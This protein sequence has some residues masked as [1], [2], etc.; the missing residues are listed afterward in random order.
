M[1]KALIVTPY[2]A[3]VGGGE[4]YMLSAASAISSLGMQVYF[5]WESAQDIEKIAL[6]LGIELP[7]FRLDKSVSSLYFAKNPL[8]MWQATRN[9]DLVLYLSDGSIPLLGGKK[10]LIHFQVPFHGVNGRSPKNFLKKKLI[11]NFIVNSG[12]T[13]KIIDAEYGISSRI[14]YPPVTEIGMPLHKENL[15]LSAGRFEPTPNIKKQD[16]L[17]E[18]FRQFSN[19]NSSCQLV[20][21]G[22]AG[23]S[24]SLW[25]DKLMEQ[26]K[27]LKISFAVNAPHEKLLDLYRRAT[28]YW[29][30]AGFGVNENTAPELVEHFGITTAESI[31][32]GCIPLVVPSGGQREI[33]ED[34]HFHWES[35]NELV[36]KSLAIIADPQPYHALL[37]EIDLTKFSA[38]QFTSRLRTILE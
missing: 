36:E 23:E 4:R 3:H 20:L 33:V 8:K 32:A 19:Q 34:N 37:S 5:A 22:A 24:S 14:V 7:E 27:G 31:S 35:T 25:V 17:I 12:F 30:A 11:N 10:N 38:K 6:T 28:I 9:Y 18:A 13:K 16:V 15:I 1:K 26:A 29:H 2:L 21:A